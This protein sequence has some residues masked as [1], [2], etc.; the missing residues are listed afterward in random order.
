MLFNVPHL[1]FIAAF[2]SPMYQLLKEG[3]LLNTGIYSNNDAVLWIM[4]SS[5]T[6][7]NALINLHQYNL[8]NLV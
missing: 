8:I 6:Q 7:P 1:A 5:N 4:F 3:V 2:A